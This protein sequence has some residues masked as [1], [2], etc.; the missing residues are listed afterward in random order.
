MEYSSVICGINKYY[1]W[2]MVVLITD[3]ILYNST[4][5]IYIMQLY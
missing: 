2:I 3:F 1:L 4:I 5:S